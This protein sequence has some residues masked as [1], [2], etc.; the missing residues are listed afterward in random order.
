[1]PTNYRPNFLFLKT[2]SSPL[3]TSFSGSFLIE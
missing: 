1:L 2:L 3:T